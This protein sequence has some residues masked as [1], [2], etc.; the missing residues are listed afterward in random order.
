MTPNSYEH[1][2]MKIDNLEHHIRNLIFP[3]QDIRELNSKLDKPLQV[4]ADKATILLDNVIKRIEEFFSRVSAL[5]R[6][7]M[8]LDRIENLLSL[9]SGEIRELNKK[10]KELAS[11]GYKHTLE[12]HIKDGEK[13]LT[14]C[15]VPLSKPTKPKRKR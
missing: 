4:S 3:L 7:F 6:K 1:L 2:V 10:T 11:E 14:S 8:N 5:E 15:E 12:L 13:N 9:L